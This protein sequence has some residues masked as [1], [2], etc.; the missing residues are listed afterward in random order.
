MR[1]LLDKLKDDNAAAVVML[2]MQ[3]GFLHDQSGGDGGDI[4]TVIKVPF[5]AHLGFT[6]KTDKKFKEM[7]SDRR[8]EFVKA[9]GMAFN[10]LF[11]RVDKTGIGK[12]GKG[13]VELSVSSAHLR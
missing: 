13:E 7:G 10:Q 1:S 4:T 6:L 2:F 12:P 11:R 9:Q 5:S 3:A 8:K